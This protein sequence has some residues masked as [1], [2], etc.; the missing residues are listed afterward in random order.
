M[1]SCVHETAK[2]IRNKITI[3]G[4]EGGIIFAV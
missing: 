3:E 4:H 1:Q 2:G